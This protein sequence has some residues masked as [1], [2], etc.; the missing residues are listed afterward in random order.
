MKMLK[1][2][3]CLVLAIAL[4]F[5]FVSCTTFAAKKPI[6]LVFGDNYPAD[7]FFSKGDLY[8]KEYVEKNTKGQVLVDYFPDSQ[9]GSGKE[10]GQAVRTGAQ[11][12]TL[13]TG[14]GLAP[15]WPKIGTIDLPYLFRDELHL[16][17]VAN[18]LPSLLDEKEMAAKTGMRILNVRIRSPRHLT[19]KFPVN[20]LED[21]KGLKVRVPQNSVSVALFKSL[22]AIPTVIP[23]TDVYQALATG[24]IGAQENPYDSIYLWKMY[25]V[26]RYCAH[27]AHQRE[28]V[29]MVINNNCWNS[30]TARQRK[31]IT[32]AAKKSAEM[33]LNDVKADEKRLYN[34]LVKEGMKFTNPDLVPFREKAK[35]MWNEFGDAELIK[36]IE[37]IK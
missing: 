13:T 19:T 25:E 34:L 10:M 20:K 29:V 7:H 14:G 22:G 4:V 26:T 21:I 35:T 2:S 17:K 24:V 15:Y 3:R 11:Q 5:V 37:A 9:L 33:G 18:K 30:L 28:L 12:I 1:K 31:I 23:M 36:K 8:F 27:T 32:D 16:L 6:K